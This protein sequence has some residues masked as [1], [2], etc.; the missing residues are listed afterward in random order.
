MSS[1]GRETSA[2]KPKYPPVI[3]PP[4]KGATFETAFAVLGGG[5]VRDGR[6]YAPFYSYVISPHAIVAG[7][8]D[9]FARW[10]AGWSSSKTSAE[11]SARL[12]S[13]AITLAE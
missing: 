4:V 11:C 7:D 6:I 13:S 8:T 5:T 10:V 12:G 9:A 1:S 2:A 3:D